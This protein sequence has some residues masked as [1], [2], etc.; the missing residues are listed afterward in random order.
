MSHD[1][2][3]DDEA[4]PLAA[5]ERIDKICLTFEDA[6]K[7]GE[8][9]RVEQYLGDTAEP[10]RTALFRELLL[11]ESYYRGH[12]GAIPAGPSGEATR[13]VAERRPGSPPGVVH[14]SS[15]GAIEHGR[16]LPGVVL[17][18][19]WRIVGLLGR[20][21]MGEVYR[22]DDLRL[23]QAV[24][25]KFLPESL[26]ADP[27]FLASLRNEVRLARQ[28]A[29]PNVCGVYDIGEVDRQHFLSMEYIDGEDLAGLLRRI[30]RLPPDKGIA[31]ARQLFAGVA[32]AHH[33]GI[34]HRDLKPANVM[35]DGRGQVRITDFGLACPTGAAADE[36]N[37]AGTPL[38]MAPEQLAGER[39]T[40]QSDLYALGL[41]LYEMFTG[42]QPFRAETVAELIRL[43]QDSA[44][45]N[46]SQL[47]ENLDPAVERVILHCLEREP[48]DRPASALAVLAALPGKDPLEAA[49]AAG[50]TPSPEMV[51]AAGEVGAI[52]PA[53]GVLCLAAVALGLVL[54]AFLS[55]KTTLVG[56][57]DLKKPDLLAERAADIIRG[58]GYNQP[59]QDSARGFAYETE[60]AG[61]TP[62]CFWYRQSPSE[63]IPELFAGSFAAEGH[64][65]VSLDDPPGPIPGEVRVRLGPQGRL[66][67]FFAVSP[68]DDPGE[69][70]LPSGP[71]WDPGPTAWYTP[72][73]CEAGLIGEG[74]E[75]V[76]PREFRPVPP[77][78][79]TAVRADVRKAWEGEC[80]TTGVPVRIEAAA[81]GGKPVYFRL[82]SREPAEGPRPTVGLP[83][84]TYGVV[85]ITLFV[86]L[87]ALAG[88]LA[89]Y[90][91]RRGRGDRRSAFRLAAYVLVVAMLA[92]LLITGRGAR[93]PRWTVFLMGMQIAVF[94][95][96]LL[97]LFYIAL[98]PYVRR[99]WPQTLISWNRLLAGRFRDPLVG[100]DLLV[101][102]T[103][104][105][106]T[107]LLW[108]ID[109]LLP[110]W[111][112]FG[113]PDL[114]GPHRA[115]FRIPLG[116]LLGGRYGVGEFFHFQGTAI[117]SGL[118]LV[119]FLL[120][121]RFVLRRQWAAVGAYVLF[122]TVV[123]SVGVGHPYFSWLIGGLT[124]A[125]VVFL[126]MRFGLVTVVS[127]TFVRLLLTFPI[128]SDLS[129]WH[130]TST[131]LLPLGAIV[132]LAAYG[133]YVSLGER[134]LLRDA[135][136]P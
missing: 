97:W 77:T 133:F 106:A 110:S 55:G 23:G 50:E 120:L 136:L 2:P 16:F 78:W 35:L 51:A 22:A 76:D 70:P 40:V 90:N 1:L 96:L 28:I 58:L 119:L 29:H 44:P 32:A 62:I 33:K 9:P 14:V 111:C 64:G 31:I 117:A 129:A 49:L 72:L 132:A 80:P 36:E 38:Y 24:A 54:V 125:L 71:G 68:A 131:T 89:R 52:R 79:T 115:H 25:L 91:L 127:Y 98:E 13:L 10:E 93:L 3:P 11:L 123:W 43:R 128:T 84:D 75:A 65:V 124:S 99:L 73:F 53:V 103:L 118:S 87:V 60:P 114:F 88:L 108:Q 17:A 4:L 7:A 94:S 45:P 39:A 82:V 21:G 86:L 26:A 30:G 95:S 102:A 113:P 61:I 63:L 134:P 57:V 107:R 34:L 41:V 83:P 46:P 59:P 126:L 5:K 81:W 42:K 12:G 56:Q 27:A 6:W 8:K 15:P 135:M 116:P 48:R 47:V 121:L 18:D 74:D 104:G 122:G 20:G 37:L 100:R 85:K 101:G 105:V 19:R 109:V 66:I 69:A 130:A 67:E 112:G 92:W